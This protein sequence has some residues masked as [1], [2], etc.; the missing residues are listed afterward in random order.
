[1]KARLYTMASIKERPAMAKCYIESNF[2]G[3]YKVT[4]LCKYVGITRQAYY[5]IL[6][7]VSL[8]RVDVALK[9]CEFFNYVVYPD[10]DYLW[11]VNDLWQLNK[12]T[13][14]DDGQIPG[15]IPLEI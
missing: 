4:T 15:Q 5:N 7:G 3:D 6:S 12:D 11:T 14:D 8:P 1:M 10:D 2:G 13:Q 9:I